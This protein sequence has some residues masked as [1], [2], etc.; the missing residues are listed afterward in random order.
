MLVPVLRA[1]GIFALLCIPVQ[2]EVP[3]RFRAC[4]EQAF[5]ARHLR[6]KDTYGYVLGE[7]QDVTVEDLHHFCDTHNIPLPE[8]RAAG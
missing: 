2:A 7:Y 5:G 8:G 1:Q 6:L 4:L 3:A